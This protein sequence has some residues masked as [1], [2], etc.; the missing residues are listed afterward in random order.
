V[1]EA[2]GIM[3]TTLTLNPDVAALL[4]EAVHAH[5][6]FKQVLNDAL[7]QALSAPTTAPGGEA[8][9]K[10]ACAVVLRSFSG[11]ALNPCRLLASAPRRSM[12]V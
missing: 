6:P 4:K 3:R 10:S 8:A 11:V 5:R 7:R 9:V 2:D 1:I 12:S